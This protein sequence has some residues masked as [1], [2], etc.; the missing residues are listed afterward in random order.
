M[1]TM[2]KRTIITALLVLIALAGQGQEESDST[3]TKERGLMLF[4]V[5]SPALH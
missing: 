5:E 4:A 3:K 1:Q 2:N